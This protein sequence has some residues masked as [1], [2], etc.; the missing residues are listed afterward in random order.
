MAGITNN[1][2][3]LMKTCYPDSENRSGNPE[4]SRLQRRTGEFFKNFMNGLIEWSCDLFP[5]KYITRT[6]TELDPR[7]DHN[8]VARQLNSHA[9]LSTT[10]Q[11]MLL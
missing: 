10:F 4:H 3:N 5:C 1:H 9:I 7:R 2:R 6:G 11:Q 8:S